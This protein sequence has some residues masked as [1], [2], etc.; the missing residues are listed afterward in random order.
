MDFSLSDEQGMLVDGALRFVRE[1]YTLD[2]YRKV[3]AGDGFNPD[4][5]AA[6]AEMGWLMLPFPADRGGLGGAPEDVGLLMTVFGHG[7]I[8]EPFATTVLLC[9]TILSRSASTRAHAL[10]GRI[11][12]GSL[13]VALAHDE[14]ALPM[15]AML[16]RMATRA[17]RTAGGY[18][19]SGDKRM[20]LDASGAD[21]LIVTAMI[22]EDVAL[23]LAPADGSGVMR[24]DYALIDGTRASDIRFEGVALGEDACIARGDDARVLLA[25]GLD[26]AAFAN[27]A[28]SVGAMEAVLDLSS[29]YLKTR[30]QFG[31]PLG[32]FQ[33]LQHIIAGLFVE[34]Q[35][36]RSILYRA[37]A[38]MRA[39]AGERARAIAQA[40]VVIGGAA[41]M[42]AR[43]GIQFHGGYGM[44]DA[45][46][47]SHHFKRLLTLEK[48]FGDSDAAL[49]RLADALAA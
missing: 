3:V 33:A 40:R 7:L 16:P 23:M 22:G 15:S 21:L 10:A 12:E 9:G 31:R 19:L 35:E 6:F 28:Q 2:H 32:S 24:S 39:P 13:R 14:D 43:A 46:A 4:N 42:I 38:A 36:A 20:V 47:V 25:D 11:A 30:E 5:W 17:E 27:L 8:I 37:T 1:R 34:A 26:W 49:D 18:R 41:Q 48:M 44:T 45:F 29:D